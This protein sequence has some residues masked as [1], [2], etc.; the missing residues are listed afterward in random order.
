LN[1]FSCSNRLQPPTPDSLRNVHAAEK[2]Q[3]REDYL[4]SNGVLKQPKAPCRPSSR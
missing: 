1:S 2:K 3:R 4:Q